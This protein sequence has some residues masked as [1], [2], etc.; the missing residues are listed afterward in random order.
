MVELRVLDGERA[1]RTRTVI[2]IDARIAGEGHDAALHR[3]HH[4]SPRHINTDATAHGVVT[5]PSVA[6]G[7]GSYQRFINQK[8]GGAGGEVES[9]AA[10]PAQGYLTHRGITAGY[11]HDR[12]QAGTHYFHFR[13]V[14]RGEAQSVDAYQF[15]RANGAQ[16]RIAHVQGLAGGIKA[17]VSIGDGYGAGQDNHSPR[18]A[19]RARELVG[20]AIA[21]AGVC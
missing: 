21:Q 15:T 20:Q 13:P 17:R 10:T 19:A 8:T 9:L 18:R 7:T 6:D 11:T 1:Y 5:G 2:E 12:G 14:K 3:T 4:A 16:I